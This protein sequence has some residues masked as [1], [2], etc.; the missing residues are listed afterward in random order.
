[1]IRVQSMALSDLT[2]GVSDANRPSSVW[3]L[4]TPCASPAATRVSRKNSEPRRSKSE[5]TEASAVVRGEDASFGNMRSWASS[6]WWS[7][8]QKWRFC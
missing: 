8:T 7:S 2:E 3:I 5:L 1:M 6:W 4:S